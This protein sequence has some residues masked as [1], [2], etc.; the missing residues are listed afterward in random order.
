MNCLEDYYINGNLKYNDIC[1]DI[2][3]EANGE[4]TG[5]HKIRGSYKN[6]ASFIFAN[7]VQTEDIIFNASTI[8]FGYLF[9]TLIPDREVTIGKNTL[10]RNKIRNSF[11]HSRYYHTGN[12]I[13]LFDWKT[14]D[15]YDVN[16]KKSIKVEDL[17]KFAEKYLEGLEQQQ[18]NA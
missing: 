9:D 4:E 6:D 5:F 11:E 3:K 18:E 16:W 2:A 13:V 15:E 14:A 10:P 1:A 17:A 8:F 7:Y 12:D